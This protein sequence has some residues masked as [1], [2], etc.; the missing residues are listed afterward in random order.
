MIVAALFVGLLLPAAPTSEPTAV[1][2]RI[3]IPHLLGGAHAAIQKMTL[4]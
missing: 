2:G 3:E 1:I 4:V